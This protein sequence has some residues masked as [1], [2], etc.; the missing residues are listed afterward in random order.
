RF[1]GTGGAACSALVETN[2]SS[3]SSD[4]LP[5]LRTAANRNGAECMCNSPEFMKYEILST[6]VESS[7]YTLAGPEPLTVATRVACTETVPAG[8]PILRARRF[9]TQV[10]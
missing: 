5:M 10:C 2:K 7:I 1:F 9:E 8:G 3:G 4:F 6:C